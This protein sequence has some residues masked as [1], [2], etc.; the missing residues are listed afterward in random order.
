M[1]IPAVSIYMTSYNE[2][3]HI[4]ECIISILGQ[5]FEN[6]ELI[7]VDDGSTDRTINKI[8]SFKDKR[9]KLYAN[10]HNYIESLNLATSL[11]KG[12]YLA[13]MDADDIMMPDRL[14][15]QYNYLEFNN[16]IDI[17][18]G[19]MQFFG[20]INTEYIP[21]VKEKDITKNNFSQD[22]IIAH[23]TVMIR[24]SSVQN[25][26]P[27]LYDEEFKYAEDYKLWLELL[28]IGL[29]FDIIPDILIK[30]RTSNKQTSFVKKE[31]QVKVTA[32]I[33][34]LFF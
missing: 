13:K 12:K 14:L 24:K 21:I 28:D 32:K 16:T 26:I 31:E 6:F 10:S 4:Q 3:R 20:T 25:L 29:K 8:E 9:I 2:E 17:L 15:I 27:N 30:Y 19:G 5:S 7:I 33:K 1:I 34:T 23:P 18:A 22:N 11:S